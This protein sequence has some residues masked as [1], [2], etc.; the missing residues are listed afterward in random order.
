MVVDF[1]Q[2][3]KQRTG[4]PFKDAL[5]GKDVTLG[6]VCCLAIEA[7]FRDETLSGKDKWKRGELS[8]KVSLNEK[9]ELTE[10]EY[11]M[12]RQLTGK[13]HSVAAVVAIWKL[14]PELPLQGS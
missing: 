12:I 7:D 14:M 8:Y 2:I 9:L 10:A 3:L 4:E 5:G 11:E 6:D 13:F 1:S